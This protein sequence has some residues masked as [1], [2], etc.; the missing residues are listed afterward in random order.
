[1]AAHA[2]RRTHSFSAA[3][4]AC[5]AA[6]AVA[7]A[8]DEAARIVAE[9]HEEAARV[10]CELVEL[11]ASARLDLN[12]ARYAIRDIELLVPDDNADPMRSTKFSA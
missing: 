11:M 5:Q 2:H 6:N 9:A 1:M 3:E 12:R 8:N 7:A 4:A 10:R